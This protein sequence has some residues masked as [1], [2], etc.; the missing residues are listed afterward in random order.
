M[1]KLADWISRFGICVVVIM[2]LLGTFLSGCKENRGKEEKHTVQKASPVPV[3]Q[4]QIIVKVNTAEQAQNGIVTSSLQ[5]TT[6]QQKLR[7]PAVVLSAQALNELRNSYV[8]ASASLDRALTSLRVSRPAY[9]RL[10]ALYQDQQNSSLSA[11][12]AAEGAMRTDE[13]NVKAAQDSLSLLESGVRQQWGSVIANWLLTNPTAFQRL[14]RQEDL[15]LQVTPSS[16]LRPLA[17]RAVRVQADDGKIS[18]A[19]FV[20][21]LPRLDPRIQAPSYLYITRANSDLT[22][23]M[24]LIVLL[25][26]GAPVRGALIPASAIVWWEGKAWAYVQ[27]APSTFIQREVPTDMAVRGGWFAAKGFSPEEK[28][29][30][31]GAQ[32]LLSEELSSQVQASRGDTD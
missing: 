16:D 32:Q 21:P 3:Q 17:P 12:Q 11:M 8:A 15:L 9:Q 26:Q 28:V 13:I 5:L 27:T 19:R 24:N 31:T 7:A 2:A 23:G 22:P 14:I 1:R 4:G 20:S 25:P 10:N 18:W 30:T 6:H 29:V